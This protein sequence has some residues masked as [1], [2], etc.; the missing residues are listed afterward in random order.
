M[1][2]LIFIAVL[3]TLAS[4]LFACSYGADPFAVPTVPSEF[5]RSD[6][7]QTDTPELPTDPDEPIFPTDPIIPDPI[8]D[9]PEP[10]EP[11]APAQDE[12]QKKAELSAQQIYALARPAVFHLLMTK[13]D[14]SQSAASGFFVDNNGTAVTNFHVIEDKVSGTATLYDGTTAEIDRVIGVN[15]DEDLAVIHLNVKN[16]VPVKKGD[17]D[18]I[19]VGDT[20]YTVGYPQSFVLGKDDSTFTVGIISKT[21]FTIDGSTYIQATASFT[22]GNSGGVLLNAY[23]EVIGVTSAIITYADIDYMNLSVPINIAAAIKRTENISLEEY[24]AKQSGVC[25][26]KFVSDGTTQDSLFVDYGKS[27]SEK[28]FER[29]GCTFEGWFTD[30]AFTKRADFSL[31]IKKDTTFYGKYTPKTGYEDFSFTSTNNELTVLGYIGSDTEITL[32]AETTSIGSYAFSGMKE[33]TG[34]EIP[35]SV[36]DVGEGAFEYC[37]SLRYNKIG[38]VNYLG[39]PSA[40]Y[41]WAIKADDD[42]GSDVTIK[43]GCVGIYDEC[44]YGLSAI[45]SVTIPSSVKVVGLWAFYNCQNITSLILSEGLIRIDMCGF[46]DCRSL[47]SVALPSSLETLD[48]YAFYNCRSLTSLHIPK[49]LTFINDAFRGVGALESITV[50]KDNGFYFAEGNCLVDRSTRTVVLGCASSVIPSSDKVV[51]IGAYAFNNCVGLETLSIPTNVTSIGACAFRGATSLK[52][53]ELH[54]RITYVGIGAYAGCTSLESISVDKNNGTYASINNCLYETAADTVIAGCAGSAVPNGTITIASYAFEGALLPSLVLPS[55]LTA[56]GVDA[57]KGCTTLRTVVIPQNVFYIANGAFANCKLDT[58]SVDESNATY[59]SENN[60]VVE[61]ASKTLIIG[62]TASTVPTDGSVTKI[63]AYAFYG[64]GLTSL[65]LPDCITEIGEYA[66]YGCRA[67]E[68]I[69]IPSGVTSVGAAAFC[70]CESLSQITLPAIK[71]IENYFFTACYALTDVNI[72]D[73]VTTV[74]NWAFDHCTSL[75]TIT[76]PRSVKTIVISAFF[77]CTS[78][79]TIYY[80]GTEEEWKAIYIGNAGNSALRRANVVFLNT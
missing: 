78:L 61:T 35:S 2:K 34:I 11:D 49:N 9:D 18:K 28:A 13:A 38:G 44:F 7:Q 45:E 41:L 31:P 72:P 25:N 52:N 73:G 80:E 50:D 37:D 43:D 19:R 51:A 6:A 30:E 69:N 68:S 17:S 27:V 67:L 40:P 62:C 10:A 63:G 65:S 8:P 71:S 76:V 55:S 14:G 60:C 54:S 79:E 57:F 23:G 64:C 21:A 58:L 39:N 32:P 36:T 70:F 33:L 74:G 5:N 1:K 20:V 53:V 24:A 3:L 75:R 16:T 15:K 29:L 59:H 48:T 47:T 42:I 26:V 4:V 46:G 12:P 66:F 77:D 56:I 22:F